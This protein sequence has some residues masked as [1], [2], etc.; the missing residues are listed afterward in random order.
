[1]DSAHFARIPLSDSKIAGKNN[2]ALRKNTLPRITFF[3]Q[4]IE[5]R[6]SHIFRIELVSIAICLCSGGSRSTVS[7][8]RSSDPASSFSFQSAASSALY[9]CDTTLIVVFD[10]PANHLS[11]VP[12]FV[13]I[14]ILITEV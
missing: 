8:S 1:M 4:D 2:F 10:S 11:K 3:D 13:Q 12:P 6:K 9:F 5:K 7:R 14:Q